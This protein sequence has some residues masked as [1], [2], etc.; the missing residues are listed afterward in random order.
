MVPD[1]HPISTWGSIE[2]T[3]IRKTPPH[4]ILDTLLTAESGPSTFIDNGRFLTMGLEVM[5]HR[6]Q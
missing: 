6:R 1:V 2:T 3:I 5:Y 4:F